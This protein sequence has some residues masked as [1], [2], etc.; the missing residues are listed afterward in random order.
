MDD[1][2]P[3]LHWEPFGDTDC[4]EC[5]DC[6]EILTDRADGLFTDGNRARCVGCDRRGQIRVDDDGAWVDWQDEYTDGERLDWLQD[7]ST[8]EL[9][10]W[11]CRP[12]KTGRGWRLHETTR[13]DGAPTIRT[14]IDRAIE[15]EESEK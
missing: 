4:P 13:E 6:A 15:E 11:V 5:G 2:K 7:R 9:F 12:S 3:E 10:S 1:K 8:P 14:A